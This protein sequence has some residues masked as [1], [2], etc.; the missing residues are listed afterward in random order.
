MKFREKQI[1]GFFALHLSDDE[2]A[3]TTAIERKLR[4]LN[5]EMQDMQYSTH[6]ENGILYNDILIMYNRRK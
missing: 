6:L 1:D 2:D 3:L 5:A 4:E